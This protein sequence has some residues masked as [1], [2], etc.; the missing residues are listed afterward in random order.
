MP[1]L[2]TIGASSAKA[3]GFTLGSSGIKLSFVDSASGVNSVTVPSSA[4]EGDFAVMYISGATGTVGTVTGWTTIDSQNA[5]FED[6]SC[7]KVL[8]NSDPGSTI[9]TPNPT[10]FDA[11]I[12]AVF[13]PSRPITNVLITSN[14]MLPAASGEAPGPITVTTGT[15]APPNLV[16]GYYANYQN[17]PTFSTPSWD[18]TVLA[19]GESSNYVLFGYLFEQQNA[20]VSISTNLS[21]G[22]YNRLSGFCANFE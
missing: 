22:S 8:T 19:N 2:S 20:D 16:I 12:V 15:H 11:M 18:G 21:T 17:V 14:T 9:P 4:Q 6:I 5:V 3:N 13:R 1:L 7:Y 10:N